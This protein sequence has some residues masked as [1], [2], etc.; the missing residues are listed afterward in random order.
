VARGTRLAVARLWYEGSSFNPV[1]TRL[2][3]F[4]AREW[5]K[6]GEAAASFAGTATEMGA[7]DDFARAHPD[8]QV[9]YPA[10]HLGTARRPGRA[11][12]SRHDHR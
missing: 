6:G 2:Q 12:R 10:L 1:L 7:V 5:V 8:W 4:R 9:V 3:Q 11:G